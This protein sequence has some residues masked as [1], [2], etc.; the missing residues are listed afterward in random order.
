VIDK[1]YDNGLLRQPLGNIQR[2]WE[3]WCKTWRANPLKA[4]CYRKRQDDK[5]RTQ[6]HELIPRKTLAAVIPAPLVGRIVAK[7]EPAVPLL[8]ACRF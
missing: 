1:K 7:S 6:L 2:L 4:A 8:R 5:N 3:S